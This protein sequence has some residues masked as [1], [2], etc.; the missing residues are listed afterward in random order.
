MTLIYRERVIAEK[1]TLDDSTERLREFVHGSVY[2]TL[3][4]EEQN[5]LLQQLGMMIGLQATLRDRI[6]FWERR[7]EPAG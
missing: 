5:L 7:T 4:V 1:A 6:A 2:P 3:A